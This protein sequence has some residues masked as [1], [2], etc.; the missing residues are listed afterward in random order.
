M[1]RHSS[2]RTVVHSNDDV[3]PT[4]KK[5]PQK[6][7]RLTAKQVADAKP[8]EKEYDLRDTESLYLTV[9]PSGSK[10]WRFRYRFRGQERR[11]GLGSYPDV[12][13]KEARTRRDEIRALARRG[14]DPRQDT[15][16]TE[17]VTGVSLR[18]FREAA[19]LF[20]ESRVAKWTVSYRTKVQR[21]LETDIFPHVGDRPIREIT[22]TE[23]LTCLKRVETERGAIDMAKRVCQ[24]C[25]MVFDFAID[26]E[27]CEFN[28]ARDI[29]RSLQQRRV[30]HYASLRTTDLPDFMVAL[31]GYEGDQLTKLAIR[32]LLL[33]F[34]RTTELR[35]AT[36][37]EI[38]FSLAQ[39]EIPAER[40]K[41]REPH[42]VP[43]SRQ[44][45]GILEELKSLNVDG[46]K[47][48]FPQTFNSKKA[49][50]ENT[51][52]FALYRMGYKGRTTGHGFRSLAST[53][54]NEARFPPDAIE[55]QL[56]HRD[57]NK[58]RAAYNRASWLVQREAMMQAWA[59]FLDDVSDL[60]K[61]SQTLRTAARSLD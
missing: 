29:P 61:A 22:R 43:L 52:L 19:T 20:I 48:V 15:A 49:M 41:A 50:S 16:T 36:W 2:G 10:W 1:I 5:E 40:M 17:G 6:A 23:L 58:V 26:M 7:V 38:N 24:R 21:S 60:A 51:I 35:F 27:W 28:V 39:W 18:T 11:T 47:Y 55:V 45:L 37:S 44:A 25:A 46:S 4:P 31:G 57:P 42:L 32:L 12:S 34:V 9:S 14:V 8:Q 59:D 33:T 30:R 56:A 3:E 53:T 54:L 13:L